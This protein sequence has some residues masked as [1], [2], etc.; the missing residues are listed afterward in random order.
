MPKKM[1]LH[2]KGSEVE[3]YVLN[4]YAKHPIAQITNSLILPRDILN[5]C[6]MKGLKQVKH[7]TVHAQL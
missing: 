3:T 7:G 2:L 5:I 1:S 6:V 4:F